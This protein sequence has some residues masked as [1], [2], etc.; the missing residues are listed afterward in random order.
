MLGDLPPAA[1]VDWPDFP[2]ND[3]FYDREQMLLS[4]LRPAF[5]HY[6]SGDDYPTAIR[7]NYGTVILPSILGAN[8]QL[9]E[10]SMPWAHHLEGRD[11]IK[12]LIDAGFPDERRPA[13]APAWTRHNGTAKHWLLTRHSRKPCGSSIPTCRDLLTSPICCG[14]RI[15]F[16]V[17]M[18]ARTWCT[19]CW[20]S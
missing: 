15:S 9:T 12:R 20:S 11:A 5:L 2:Y 10:N 18:I 7:A 1:D 6:R 16:W 4:Q 19:A 13:A 14:G 3:T 8:W 17:S